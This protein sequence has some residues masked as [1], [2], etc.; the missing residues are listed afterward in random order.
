M[1]RGAARMI[2]SAMR[3]VYDVDAVRETLRRSHAVRAQGETCNDLLLIHAAI[4]ACRK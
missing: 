3:E 4:L 2:A 1:S